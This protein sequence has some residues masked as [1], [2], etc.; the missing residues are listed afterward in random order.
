MFTFSS[1]IGKKIACFFTYSVLLTF[2]SYFTFELLLNFLKVINRFG[3]K[4]EVKN[5]F[6]SLKKESVE[7]FQDLVIFISC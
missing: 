7:N 4:N 6:I 3:N 5:Y 1:F 2:R